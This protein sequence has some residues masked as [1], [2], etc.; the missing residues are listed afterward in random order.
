MP[1]DANANLVGFMCMTL[2]MVGSGRCLRWLEDENPNASSKVACS[3]FHQARG[4]FR[5]AACFWTDAEPAA[6]CSVL[7][8]DKA[9]FFRLGRGADL[10]SIDGEQDAESHHRNHP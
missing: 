4:A 3:D 10:R 7:F 2:S 5:V 8:L 1:I 9:R 6:E